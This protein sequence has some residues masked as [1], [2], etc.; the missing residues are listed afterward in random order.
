M[1]TNKAELDYPLILINEYATG[2]HFQK[3]FNI[4]DDERQK[5]VVK[6]LKT[7]PYNIPEHNSFLWDKGFKDIPMDHK[8]LYYYNTGGFIE[9]FKSRE[10]KAQKSILKD[11]I[12]Y[13]YIN[14]TV[15]KW[16]EENERD[17]LREV[18]M[19]G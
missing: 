18:S 14:D 12:D 13:D 16:L 11:I 1:Q 19:D 5:K 15:A 2:K 4:L 17:L 10:P 8:E 6:A 3:Y 9:Y 7:I